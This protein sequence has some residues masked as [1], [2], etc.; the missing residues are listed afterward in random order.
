M[1]NKSKIRSKGGQFKKGTSGN[2]SGRPTGSRNRATLMAEQY[3]EGQSEK[4]IRKVVD[5]ADGGNIL[6]MRLCLERVIPI[7]KERSIELDLPP[8]QNA[9][10]LVASFQRILA[11]VGE[12]RITPGEAQTLTEVLSTQAHL[13]KIAGIER[14]A[15]QFEGFGLKAA[16][17]YR[18][19]QEMDMRAI[20][21][22]FNTEDLDD[23]N[24]ETA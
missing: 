16:A 18:H 3:L 12:G 14:R 6:A 22:R 13:F 7:R 20:D 2:P 21:A 1:A 9:Q 24:R 10:D 5:M 8:A 11:A 17:A 19:Q 15:Q 23:E 4:L